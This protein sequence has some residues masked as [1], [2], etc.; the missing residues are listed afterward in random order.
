MPTGAAVTAG[1]ELGYWIGLHLTPR[2]GA[3]RIGVLI[4]RFGSAEAAWTAPER[5]LLA[6]GLSAD[7]VA[8]LLA[9][10]A[11]VDPA[12]EVERLERLGVH[13][14]TI[15]DDA[16]PRLLRHIASP[17]P[18]LYVRG[19]L[20]VADE[21]AVALV[22]TRRATAYGHDMTRRLAT[23]LAQAGVTVVSGLA[24]GID[25]TAHKAALDAGGRTVAVFACGLD[26]VY[27]PQN[28]TLAERI[29]A[30]GALVS[31]YP[32]GT[33]PDARNFP[34]RNRIISGLSR[35]IVV[36]EAPSKSG[37]LITATFAGDQ[38]RDVYAVPGSALAFTSAGCHQ[39]I[40]DGATL[41]TSAEHVLE[42]LQ[43]EAIQQHSQARVELPET[44]AERIL[45]A[46]VGAEPRH[47]DELCHESGLPVHETSG[48]LMA[49]ELKGLVR[50]AG[51]QYYVRN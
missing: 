8:S 33:R 38:G 15:A 27:P 21:L 51:A 23:D 48:T 46:I 25:T 12:R 13:A 19:E 7:V 36:V 20:R 16:Y 37:A 5:E 22:G 24:R 14:L 3:A 49:L 4:D 35:G 45:L 1:A 18:V 11:R 2:V 43:V 44:D 6:S 34:V 9:T 39:L 32:L 47:I 26:E 30:Q 41:I 31:E 42:Q 40:R 50:Q 17:P 29:V 10:R 28:R